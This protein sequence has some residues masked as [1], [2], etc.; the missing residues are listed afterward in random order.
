MSSFLGLDVVGRVARHNFKSV[1]MSFISLFNLAF[2]FVKKGSNNYC[3]Y[4]VTNDTA[5]QDNTR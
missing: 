3:V 4:F 2:S 1:K 5:S